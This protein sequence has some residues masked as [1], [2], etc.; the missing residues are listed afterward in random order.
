[1]KGYVYN[2]LGI[3]NFYNF[4]EKS[5]KLTSQQPNSNEGTLDVVG[6]I[7]K[8]FEVG[9]YNLKESVQHFEN[10]NAKYEALDSQKEAAGA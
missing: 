7:M 8:H 6:E 5:T 1:M 4:I 2:N 10:F 3:T 9:I